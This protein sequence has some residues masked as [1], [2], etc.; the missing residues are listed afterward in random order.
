M[1]DDKQETWRLAMIAKGHTPKIDRDFGG[2]LHIYVMDAGHHNGP[3]CDT[4]GWSICWHCDGVESIP[5]CA[6]PA[7]ELTATEIKLIGAK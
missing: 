1:S 6:D 2:G 3:G 5:Q 4:C 7:L